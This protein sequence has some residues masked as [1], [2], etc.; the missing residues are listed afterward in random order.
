MI[1]QAITYQE[2]EQLIDFLPSEN[3]CFLDSAT[4]H[5]AL[6]R[7]S[8]I[9]VDPFDQLELKQPQEKPLEAIKN[10]LKRFSLPKDPDLPP[11]QGGLI[12]YFAYELGFLLEPGIKTTEHAKKFPHR[13]YQLG[14]F[15]LVLSFDHMQKKAW[16]ISSGFPETVEEK[17]L[18]RARIRLKWLNELIEKR[19]IV[20]RKIPTEI[21]I[22]QCDTSHKEYINK[23]KRIINYIKAGDIFEA[24]LARCYCSQLVKPLDAIELYK[25]LRQKNPAPFSSLLNFLPCRILSSSPERFIQLSD[26]RVE[27]RPIKGTIC[28]SANESQDQRLRQELL[29]SEKDRAENIMIVDL[30]R[31]DLSKVCLA[32]SIHVPQLCQLESYKKVHHLVS[33]ITGELK[34][35]QSAIDLLT[36]VFPGGSIT[37]APK[38]RAMEI[39]NE[40]ENTQRGPYCGCVGY[41]GFNGEM[42]TSITIRTLLL[43]DDQLRFH[44]GGAITLAS[45]PQKEYQETA[46]KA[47]ALKDAISS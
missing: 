21:P 6:G 47:E 35:N 27:T 25:I 14:C 18:H 44:T 26:N 33:V 37:G 3:L 1:K 13:Y 12:G 30:M 29:Q 43:N 4:R 16:I 40:L 41:L 15:D 17:R 11:F 28:R 36:A 2:P 45:D 24:N 8:Y 22:P 32:D 38:I 23:V 5:E 19:E 34:P 46:I 9:G 31:N 39:I 10:F 20:Q 7:Y 42:D